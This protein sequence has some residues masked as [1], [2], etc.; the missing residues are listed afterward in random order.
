M[1]LKRLTPRHIIIK[2]K[3][4]KKRFQKVAREKGLITHQKILNKIINVLLI[5]NFEAQRQWVNIFKALKQ[6]STCQ[7]IVLYLYNCPLK[8]PE[9]L[10][11]SQIKAKEVYYY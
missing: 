11:H 7:K 1:N 4:D 6:T 2:L 8:V 10:K 3:K 5:R 9:K